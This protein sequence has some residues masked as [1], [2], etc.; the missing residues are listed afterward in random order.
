[1]PKTYC[2]VIIKFILERVKERVENLFTNG[3]ARTKTIRQSNP[4]PHD[5]EH[6]SADNLALESGK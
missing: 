2:K 3:K 6:R 1:M 4:S 5:H